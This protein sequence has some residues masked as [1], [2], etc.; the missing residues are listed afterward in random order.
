[1]HQTRVLIVDSDPGIRRLVKTS[2]EDR[3]YKIQTAGDWEEARRSIEREL[4]DLTIANVI[5]E[6]MVGAEICRNIREWSQTLVLMLGSREKSGYETE[7][8]DAGADAFLFIPFKTDDLVAH[9]KA[10]L[11]RTGSLDCS[12][13]RSSFNTGDL[14]I[15]FQERRVTMADREVRLTPTEYNLLQELALNPNKVLT[16]TL[17]LKKIWGPEYG[18]EREYLRIFVGRLRKKLEPDPQKPNYIVT[19]PWVGYKLNLNTP[20]SNF[21]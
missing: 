7:C 13:T 9:I 2:L 11:R 6:K 18:Q 16:H 1:M 14:E 4:P 10:L 17:L 21:N 19:V 5:L 15:Q 3:G 8:L 12:V 20:T